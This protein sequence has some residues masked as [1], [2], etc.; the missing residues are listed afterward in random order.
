[1]RRVCDILFEW[2]NNSPSAALRGGFFISIRE[3][4]DPRLSGWA[5]AKASGLFPASSSPAAGRS[6]RAAETGHPFTEKI[7]MTPTVG[8]GVAHHLR[9]ADDIA[10]PLKQRMAAAGLD[11][12]T[13]IATASPG[14]LAAWVVAA[15][16]PRQTVGSALNDIAGLRSHLGSFGDSLTAVFAAARA[17]CDRPSLAFVVQCD[18][19]IARDRDG[20]VLALVHGAACDDTDASRLAPLNVVYAAPGAVGADLRFTAR[21]PGHALAGLAL[22]AA[23]FERDFADARVRDASETRIIRRAEG[24]RLTRAE[25]LEAA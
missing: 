21:L 4:R 13:P 17:E 9:L 25:G 23:G 2:E 14:D 10:G 8:D 12:D 18:L 20:A 3:P 11:P 19:I 15:L 6:L 7:P 22:E 16:A 5:G 1:M 24:H